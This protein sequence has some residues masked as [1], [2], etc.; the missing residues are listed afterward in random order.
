MRFALCMAAALLSIPAW[1]ADLNGTWKGKAETPN[2]TFERTFTFH[3]DG[4]TLTGE[5][6]SERMGKS[7]IT[8][9][10]VD[11]DNLSFTIQVKFQDNE[12]KLQ[13]KGKVVGEEI[14]LTVETPDG[15]NSFEY[16]LKKAS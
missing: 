4:N 16:N 1:A 14:K 2:G 3:V 10:K 7:V 6:V 8:D 15:G 9:G 13:Y 11:G 12:M 5:T